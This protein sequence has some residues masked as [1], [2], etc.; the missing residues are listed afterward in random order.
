MKDGLRDLEREKAAAEEAV[1][2]SPS[3]GGKREGLLELPHED[4]DLTSAPLA[5][6]T[7]C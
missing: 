1:L 5:W 6:G 7:R 3:R 2:T 4:G